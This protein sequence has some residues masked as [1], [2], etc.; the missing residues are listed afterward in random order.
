[1]ANPETLIKWFRFVCVSYLL[2][3]AIL[4]LLMMLGDGSDTRARRRD[5]RRK[6]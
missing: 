3:L 4:P 2:I 6:G 5:A 1:M